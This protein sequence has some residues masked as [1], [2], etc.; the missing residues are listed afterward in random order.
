MMILAYFYDRWNKKKMDE[1]DQACARLIQ[2]CPC[3]ACAEVDIHVFPSDVELARH[4]KD[5]QDL[6]KG[7]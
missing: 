6:M 7:M 4:R 1:I 3:P 2:G 5:L